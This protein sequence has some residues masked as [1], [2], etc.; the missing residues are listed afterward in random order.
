VIFAVDRNGDEFIQQYLLPAGGGEAEPLTDAPEAQHEL[1]NVSPDGRWLS[2]AGNDRDPASQD[3]LIRDLT[4][5]E[6]LRVPG[7]G[8]YMSPGRWSPDSSRF[9]AM[10]FRNTLDQPVY[11]AGP[12]T[13]AR[14]LRKPDAPPA[15]TTIGPWY[16]DGILVL[17]DAGREFTGVARMD[18]Q[19]RRSAVDGAAGLGRGTCGPVL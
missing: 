18:A 14:S 3:L 1:G 12:D 16:D 5:G 10:D 19:G 4:T 6:I 8:G 9:S 13:R 2:Y 11:V 15:K 7:A 17:T